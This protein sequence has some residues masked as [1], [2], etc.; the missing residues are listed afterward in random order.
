MQV[1]KALI[2]K[3]KDLQAKIQLERHEEKSL[4]DV[5]REVASSENWKNIEEEILK[6]KKFLF[7]ID[8]RR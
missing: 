4:T 6:R 3:L 2:I 5:T 8:K 1:D 7:R